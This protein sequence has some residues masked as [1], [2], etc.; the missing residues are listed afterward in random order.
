MK[1]LFTIF[2]IL[3][4]LFFAVEESCAR[5]EIRFYI[6]IGIVIGGLTI[7]LSIG[8][9]DISGFLESDPVLVSEDFYSPA[10]GIRILSW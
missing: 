10:S 1:K 8:G 7:F 4:F 6:S 3:I 2:I 5:T 9:S